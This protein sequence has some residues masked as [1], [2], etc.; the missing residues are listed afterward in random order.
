MR[1]LLTLGQ[2]RST[3][4]MKRDASLCSYNLPFIVYFY[5]L[6]YIDC[7]AKDEPRYRLRRYREPLFES[8]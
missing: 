1:V 6:V 7:Q 3:M 4:R 8:G 5:L 2:N